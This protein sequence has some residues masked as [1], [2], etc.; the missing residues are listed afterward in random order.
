[1]EPDRA[2]GR[3]SDRGA[4]VAC[5]PWNKSEVGRASEPESPTTGVTGGLGERLRHQSR[6]GCAPHR[7]GKERPTVVRRRDIV[8]AES[9][10]RPGDYRLFAFSRKPT[11][12]Q[13]ATCALKHP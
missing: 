8:R 11:R 2:S 3:D 1:M 10:K 13:L 12:V 9:V 7:V 5:D 4:E 6:K